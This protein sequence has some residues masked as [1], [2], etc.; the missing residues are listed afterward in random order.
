M[1]LADRRALFNPYDREIGPYVVESVLEIRKRLT[2]DLQDIA[3]DNVLAQ[4]LQ[5]MQATCR[6]FLDDNQTPRRVY[7]WPYE[8]QLQS[9]LGELRARFGVHIARLACAY[10]LE[11]DECLETILPP[12]SDDEAARAKE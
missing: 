9:T 8:A 10:D 1:Y 5:A 6:K 3:P 12:P 7:G 11:I 2:E 4:S